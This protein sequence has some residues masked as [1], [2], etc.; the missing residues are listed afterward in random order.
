MADWKDRL[1]GSPSA[2]VSCVPVGTSPVLI[3]TAFDGRTCL[4]LQPD[5]AIFVGVATNFN[6]TNSCIG[7][8]ASGGYYQER[9]YRGPVY[10]KAEGA[11]GVVRRFEV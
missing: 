2:I 8:V 3:A 9:D 10:V 1:T 11:T 4:T 5:L 6:A 7:F